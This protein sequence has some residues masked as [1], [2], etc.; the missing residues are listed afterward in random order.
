VQVVARLLHPSQHHFDGAVDTNAID[1]AGI[2]RMGDTVLRAAG[3]LW[4]ATL[5]RP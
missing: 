3:E 5:E 2:G 1:V 4:A